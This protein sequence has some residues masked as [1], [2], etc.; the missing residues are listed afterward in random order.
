VIRDGIGGPVL[1]SVH[2]NQRLAPAG[3]SIGGRPFE[4]LDRITITSDTLV[5]EMSN[6]S[7]PQVVIAD[8]T[9]IQSVTPPA[10]TPELT[11]RSNS[12]E[13]ADGGTF[14]LPMTTVGVPASHTFTVRNDGSS[15]L[16]LQPISVSGSAFSIAAPNFTPD[17]ILPPGQQTSFTVNV[18][19]SASGLFNG[20]L[21]FANNDADENPFDLVLRADVRPPA[22]PTVTIDDGDPGFALT[23]NWINVPGFGFEADAKV[24]T[25]N[26]VGSATWTFTGLAAGDYN[27]ATTWLSGSDRASSVPY[28]IRDGVAG[29]ILATVQVDQRVAPNG[30]VHGGRPLQNLSVVTLTG[31][32]LV[33]ELSNAGADGH[34]IADAV[35]I[36][37]T[38]PAPSTPELTVTESGVTIADG[39]SFNFGSALQMSP[40]F[41]KTFVVQNT[42]TGNLTLEP[43]SVTGSGF[44]LESANFMPGQ[45]LAPGATATFAIGLSTTTVGTFN[46]EVSFLHNDADEN[47]FDIA[48]SGTINPLQPS[49]VQIIDNGD[50]GFNSIGNFV[51]VNGFG[52]GGDALAGNGIN[53][54]E[55]AQWV[56]N[57]LTA[58]DF[59]VST[60][61]LRGGD[62][63][64]AVSY[65]IRD[66]IGGTVLA[67]VVVDQRQNPSGNAFGGRPFQVLDTV[68]LTGSTLVV[69]LSTAG[70]TGAVI[71]DAV[72]IQRL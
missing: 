54:T 44:S 34:V 64:A 60:T 33:V 37:L 4:V 21:S 40:P 58:G 31:D 23:S 62:R 2:V 71:A 24:I 3:P 9:L 49:G 70:S 7:A 36:E 14:V 25:R 12:S 53:G 51:D 18:D 29:P 42:G 20:T 6:E 55:T 22:P 26:R 41:T 46:G 63:E 69:E 59:E 32:T 19:T 11:V 47:P 28:V 66:G 67:T 35:R 65:V 43:I 30:P 50:T 38:T 52:F 16:I 45:M 48:V 27:V 39:S 5:I 56:F 8:A 1:A 17:Q 72:R 68:S 61:W 13:I 10:E 15:D 57:G